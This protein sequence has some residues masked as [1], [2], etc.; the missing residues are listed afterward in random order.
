MSTSVFFDFC[1]SMC[2]FFA[3]LPWS[4][5]GLLSVWFLVSAAALS[6]VWVSKP[7]QFFK[8]PSTRRRLTPALRLHLW[9]LQHRKCR[10]SHPYM[11][12]NVAPKRGSADG[13]RFVYVRRHS[14]P[15]VNRPYATTSV[16]GLR[17]NKVPPVGPKVSVPGSRTSSSKKFGSS[18][19][20]CGPERGKMIDPVI[21]TGSLHL[22]SVIAERRRVLPWC[23]GDKPSLRQGTQYQRIIS[24]GIQYEFY[25]RFG[26]VK[27]KLVW[28]FAKQFDADTPGP[29][30]VSDAT[31]VLWYVSRKTRNR[32]QHAKNGNI[33]FE[34]L[35]DI[36]LYGIPIAVFAVYLILGFATC[37]F[38]ISNYAC[39]GRKQVR[40][41]RRGK[42]ANLMNAEDGDE[43]I[44][45]VIGLLVT[46]R[47]ML[48]ARRG[49]ASKPADIHGRL[50]GIGGKIDSR[51]DLIAGLNREVMEEVS[52][53][54][55]E[56]KTLVI[57][58]VLGEGYTKCFVLVYMDEEVVPV[59]PAAEQQKVVDP[60]WYP[61]DALPY[62]EVVFDMP[63]VLITAKRY[64]NRSY[65]LSGSLPMDAKWMTRD[66]RMLPQ[67]Y[68]VCYIN[69]KNAMCLIYAINACL[70]PAKQLDYD[71]W[72]RR[73][74]PNGLSIHDVL[75]EG[76]LA[77]EVFAV[78]DTDDQQWSIS[79]PERAT[80]LLAY[81]RNG[82]QG[83]WDALRRSVNKESPV[84]YVFYPQ[85]RES[86]LQRYGGNPM[87]A[88]VTEHVTQTDNVDDCVK[89][90]TV[91]SVLTDAMQNGHEWIIGIKPE[92][93]AH[94]IDTI[95]AD[96][97]KLPLLDVYKTYTAEQWDT[98][99]NNSLPPPRHPAEGVSISARGPTVSNVPS[100]NAQQGASALDVA[101]VVPELYFTG[102][103]EV[104][105]V[106]EDTLLQPVVING[107]DDIYR[108]I[109]FDETYKPGSQATGISRLMAAIYDY[110]L[111][112][113]VS[114]YTNRHAQT[115][116]V[117]TRMNDSGAEHM[118]T[119][120]MDLSRYSDAHR[121][122]LVSN[123]MPQ[124]HPDRAA[125]I[126]R[127]L[128]AIFPVFNQ[129]GAQ[130]NIV[131]RAMLAI[132]SLAD[133][134]ANGVEYWYERLWSGFFA[135]QMAGATARVGLP[136]HQET[137]YPDNDGWAFIFGARAIRPGGYVG[138]VLTP[139]GN[140]GVT[141][142]SILS[143]RQF[144]EGRYPAVNPAVR[145]WRV[146]LNAMTMTSMGLRLPDTWAAPVNAAGARQ[147]YSVFLDAHNFRLPNISFLLAFT[148]PAT[149]QQPLNPAA[150]ANPLSWLDAMAMLLQNFGGSA[151][152]I[153]GLQNSI[154]TSARFISPMVTE[155]PTPPHQRFVVGGA[156]WDTLLRRLIHLRM[157]MPHTIANDHARTGQAWA[158]TYCV[159][160]TVKY[161]GDDLTASVFTALPQGAPERVL[162][163]RYL[164]N[165][166]D[167][168]I[169]E[170]LP[171]AIPLNSETEAAV[172]WHQYFAGFDVL[173]PHDMQSVLSGMTTRELM[174]L[175]VWLAQDYQATFH[176]GPS[177]GDRLLWFVGISRIP[178]ASEDI[179]QD[180]RIA[181]VSAGAFIDR[182][183]SLNVL[184]LRE[185]RQV[186]APAGISL[187]LSHK[188]GTEVY[189]ND[190][191]ALILAGKLIAMDPQ[192]LV[193]RFAVIATQ[194]RA[195]A[196]T[197]ASGMS[198]TTAKITS[199]TATPRTGNIA[200]DDRIINATEAHLVGGMRDM[201][202]TYVANVSSMISG[203]GYPT[204]FGVEHTSGVTTFEFPDPAPFVYENILGNHN[205]TAMLLIY[206]VLHNVVA[207][208][209]LPPSEMLGGVLR[210]DTRYTST[211][212][213]GN[214]TPWSLWR[215]KT[216]AVN[217]VEVMGGLRILAANSGYIIQLEAL[218][219][220]KSVRGGSRLRDY[221]IMGDILHLAPRRSD[222]AP[223]S[224]TLAVEPMW[225]L[226]PTTSF[227]LEALAINEDDLFVAQGAAY[228][229]TNLACLSDLPPTLPFGSA[230]GIRTDGFNL[231]RLITNFDHVGYQAHQG[232]IAPAVAVGGMHYN[233]DQA[234]TNVNGTPHQDIT[235]FES[236]HTK[237]TSAN[238]SYNRG[239]QGV[240]GYAGNLAAI[241]AN[242]PVTNI[243]GVP[244]AQGTFGLGVPITTVPYLVTY[245]PV[246]DAAIEVA[247]HMLF[248]TKQQPIWMARF[249]SWAYKPRFHRL[250]INN[251]LT[252]PI[253]MSN[254]VTDLIP[255][256][257]NTVAFPVLEISYLRGTM[258]RI[259]THAE[260]S[261][262]ET[263]REPEPELQRQLAYN[264]PISAET[265]R[266]S[267]LH[268]TSGLSAKQTRPG[269]SSLTGDAEL[270]R[271]RSDPLPTGNSNGI[272]YINPYETRYGK[273]AAVRAAKEKSFLA[274]LA[275][276]T[277]LTH[278]R[279]TGF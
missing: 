205:P 222:S 57:H 174:N 147:R 60:T 45:V 80:I 210:V 29:W 262:V 180:E 201:I 81:T 181:A 237:Q 62:E 24:D 197:V 63:E 248:F 158:T 44:S 132:T 84:D 140:S 232:P 21:K 256:S 233:L 47:S 91:A 19:R 43:P 153:A 106:R 257:D 65:T 155:L 55:S 190:D 102:G 149:L 75:K 139:S 217:P 66:F 15:K 95:G 114:V 68:D 245:L 166:V 143:M 145:D 120:Y 144:T 204:S 11:G 90:D 3:G 208:A 202:N 229:Y 270:Q 253:E 230:S 113:V 161:S 241:S 225:Y 278:K 150:L 28:R 76:F 20:F 50:A 215:I 154:R 224:Y 189:H 135:V 272:T 125:Q 218:T 170:W 116:V 41:N 34:Y 58:T 10:R 211:Y 243:A 2:C 123:V 266:Y 93:T 56:Q 219:K 236:W 156:M 186:T 30:N 17:T 111:E 277:M 185:V 108:E 254:M 263:L 235:L 175:H 260:S 252:G 6:V 234:V 107:R 83:H 261:S 137:L 249:T 160:N 171:D 98:A 251:G 96:R 18:I 71:Y 214:L 182:R 1:L 130:A 244:L 64:A 141:G 70:T 247:E 27:T 183:R 51:E 195:A 231:H 23:P 4:S 152:C 72:S 89:P 216:T 101:P 162:V 48:L 110:S 200:L 33:Y 267:G 268:L 188:I 276:A 212:V 134:G 136:V 124:S 192:T 167:A 194:W 31:S 207:K 133:R 223:W 177:F 187:L 169:T 105:N 25:E 115:A 42:S 9:R 13:P 22:P 151:A 118:T 54:I 203:I 172:F 35:L 52:I 16:D 37:Y 178:G 199:K 46:P 129:A 14:L 61:L 73:I 271:M 179:P 184:N 198:I 191:A 97:S 196:D 12:P 94:I 274:Q 79:P 264:A 117:Q 77:D 103:L 265:E 53:D 279:R 220:F 173:V 227:M 99:I 121:L 142:V 49:P 126:V 246:P 193:N 138:G 5:F 88:P 163:N 209:Y 148:P 36:D 221:P 146:V 26:S 242:L 273:S 38:M 259:G 239:L 168:E 226:S 213:R 104:V 59:V 92:Y 131:N 240:Y 250:P 67:G 85:G 40:I 159:M 128:Q 164:P 8:K 86:M 206:R 87:E 119:T 74:G 69:N 39:S 127:D 157:I 176:L 269:L 32:L 82:L 109:E 228:G 100:M 238:R 78:W 255:G 258:D 275:Q 112:D 122:S 7:A 165:L